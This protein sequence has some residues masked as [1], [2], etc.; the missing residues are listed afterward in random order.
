[1]RNSLPDH[2]LGSRWYKLYD[3]PL[4]A[5]TLCITC[6]GIVFIYSAT[7][8]SESEFVRTFHLRQIEWAV[9]GLIVLLVLSAVDYR[10]LERFAYIF[11]FILIV[12]LVK[13]TVSGKFVAGSAR[14]ISVGGMN[15]QPSEMMKVVL[16]ITLA[17]YFDDTASG[18]EM[19][20]RQLAIPA[21]ITLVPAVLIARQPDLGTAVVL[22]FI[23]TVMAY[24][25]GIRKKTLSTIATASIVA[26][27]AFWF[28]L[29]DYQ[30]DRI[31]ALLDPASDPL[32]IGYHTIQS[33]IAIGSGGLY[34]KGL[35]AGTQS[36]LNFLPEKHTDFIFSV[37]SEEIGF[38]GAIVL[39]LL[40][41]FLLMR[42]LDIMLKAK[43]RG[44]S[45][46][47]AGGV[48]M[49]AFHILY[50]VSMTLGITPIVGIP[51]PFFSYGGSA[52]LTN[53]AVIGVLLSVGTRR[54]RHD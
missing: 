33:K 8:S 40:Y 32:G 16:I 49:M 1:M 11:Y 48:A 18:R 6:M 38:V 13:V 50:N 3:W 15:I 42:M 20:L 22:M 23:F 4:L 26:I 47:A 7:F 9:Y 19:G 34:G 43:D 44:G 35:F 25:N 37:F 52:L 10:Q 41:L 31:I 29:K 17:R 21:G 5:L 27:P 28:S 24:A 54:Y 46:L 39:I 30:K 14:W 51:L 45:L 12:L 2:H 53:Y 36:K